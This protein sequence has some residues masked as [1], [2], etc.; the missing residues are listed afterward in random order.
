M[1]AKPTTPAH[2]RRLAL[3]RMLAILGSTIVFASLLT[4]PGVVAQDP[5]TAAELGI[6]RE[7]GA[8]CELTDTECLGGDLCLSGAVAQVS[9][10]ALAAE[11][12]L[13]PYLASAAVN[14]KIQGVGNPDVGTGTPKEAACQYTYPGSGYT[15]STFN[16][17]QVTTVK[18]V[19][20][21]SIS[22]CNQAQGTYCQGTTRPSNGN[23]D[24][25]HQTSSGTITAWCLAV[26]NG[27]AVTAC[28]AQFGQTFTRFDGWAI[29]AAHGH[30]LYTTCDGALAHCVYGYF[31]GLSRG[32]A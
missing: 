26:S 31:M 22:W 21:H 15:Q 13:G 25:N 3:P 32:K 24:L 6:P 18:S 4:L 23:I 29:H 11:A 28:T 14:V 12:A 5:G 27:V 17:Y 20:Y 10:C 30:G 16:C 7:G 19:T 1:N 9:P 8:R 2:A